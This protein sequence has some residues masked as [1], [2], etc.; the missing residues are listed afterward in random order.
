MFFICAAVRVF[1]TLMCH[2]FA[3]F[4]CCA[5]LILSGSVLGILLSGHITMFTHLLQNLTCFMWVLQVG[6]VSC[7]KY[8]QMHNI[9]SRIKCD[10]DLYDEYIFIISGGSCCVSLKLKDFHD[11][12]KVFGQLQ[13]LFMHQCVVSLVIL[14]DFWASFSGSLAL[15]KIIT[16]SSAP[17]NNVG[18]CM[19]ILFSLMMKEKFVLILSYAN[20]Q[21]ISIMFLK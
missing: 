5:L 4:V 13:A 21:S 15:N 7:I 20:M 16:H 6:H 3:L 18:G 2:W 1:R 11:C 14:S 12:F 10:L 9:L 19:H 17:R 8:H